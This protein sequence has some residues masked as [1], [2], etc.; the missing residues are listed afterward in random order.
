MLNP[1]YCE[2][3]LGFGDACDEFCPGFGVTHSA[4]NPFQPLSSHSLKISSGPHPFFAASA[5]S[6]P[7]VLTTRWVIAPHLFLR[8][9]RFTSSTCSVVMRSG[10]KSISA[11][12]GSC[13]SF[14]SSSLLKFFTSLGVVVCWL[15]AGCL[16]VS[17]LIL[18]IVSY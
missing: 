8:R 2:N 3:A 5:N 15:F 13:L 7:R 14:L 9:I 18:V 10:E 4:L 1:C 12:A 16:L 17:V 11:P 6:L